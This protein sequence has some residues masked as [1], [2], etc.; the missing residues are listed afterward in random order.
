MARHEKSRQPFSGE[1]L[2]KVRFR[3]G[4]DGKLEIVAP[5]KK[6]T[7][8]IEPAERPPQPEDPRPFGSHGPY[9]F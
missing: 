7:P 1:P 5:E 2:S 8:T 6:V 4:A 3:K 9:A